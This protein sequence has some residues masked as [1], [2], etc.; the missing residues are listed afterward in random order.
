MTT[1][2]WILAGLGGLIV[3]GLLFWTLFSLISGVRDRHTR[4]DTPPGAGEAL[5][6]RLARGEIGLDEYE[7]IHTALQVPAG[8][9]RDATPNQPPA[10]TSA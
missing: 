2:W 6:R 5:E 8:E 7:R 4:R 10:A 1:A 3:W 9:S